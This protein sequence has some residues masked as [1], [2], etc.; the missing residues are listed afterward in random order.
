MYVQSFTPYQHITSGI[1]SCYR[2]VVANSLADSGQ[3]GAGRA[4][5]GPRTA[6]HDRPTAAAHLRDSRRALP[7][8]L[9]GP[10][11]RAAP[12]GRAFPAGGARHRAVGHGGTPAA[13]RPR[14]ANRRPAGHRAEPGRGRGRGARGAGPPPA[15]GNGGRGNGTYVGGPAKAPILP[16]FHAQPGNHVG[17]ERPRSIGKQAVPRDDKGRRQKLIYYRM[18]RNSR[19]L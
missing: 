15:N 17:G 18:T 12:P 6:S 7:A 3:R 2:P 5:P 1:R 4:I 9:P 13:A 11:L 14:R 16:I 8:R 10:R 19:E